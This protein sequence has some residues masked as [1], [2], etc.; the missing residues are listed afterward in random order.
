[1][2]GVESDGRWSW[3]GSGSGVNACECVLTS[4]IGRLVV[5]PALLDMQRDARLVNWNIACRD[6]W[7]DCRMVVRGAARAFTTV[8]VRTTYGRQTQVSQA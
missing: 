3:C 2:G 1:M 4:W 8:G 7:R 5:T 6:D